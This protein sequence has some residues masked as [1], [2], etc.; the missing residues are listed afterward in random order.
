[1]G[2][3]DFLFGKEKPKKFEG[4]STEERNR[5]L[6][7]AQAKRDRKAAKTRKL[8]ESGQLQT[9]AQPVWVPFHKAAKDLGMKYD[10]VDMAHESD[11]TEVFEPARLEE[12]EE[13]Q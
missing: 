9:S 1:M 4:Q 6:A 12:K 11:R 10:G 8:V 3:M 7:A 5:A 2:L 13:Q